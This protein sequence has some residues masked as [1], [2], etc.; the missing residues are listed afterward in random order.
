MPPG[1]LPLFLAEGFSIEAKAVPA[2][3]AGTVSDITRRQANGT[4]LEKRETS[5]DL[6]PLYRA[7]R[8]VIGSSPSLAPPPGEGAFVFVSPPKMGSHTNPLGSI[9]QALLLDDPWRL[10]FPRPVHFFMRNDPQGQNN[11]NKAPNFQPTL[12][13]RRK[14]PLFLV[15]LKV[16]LRTR[17]TLALLSGFPN[18][19]LAIGGENKLFTH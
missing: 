16:I 14:Y 10:G 2:A 6:K 1:F 4:G 15:N 18:S 3:T 8:A 5:Q 9:A 19:W 13:R 17:L 12:R 11:Y 7:G